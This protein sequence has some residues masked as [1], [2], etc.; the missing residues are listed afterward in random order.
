MLCALLVACAPSGQT[1]QSGA[2]GPSGP[3]AATAMP[4]AQDAPSATGSL[5]DGPTG[6]QTGDT[7]PASPAMARDGLPTGLPFASAGEPRVHMPAP[8]APSA[9][10][11]A[12]VAA[13]RGL[14]DFAL[15]EPQGQDGPSGQG[16][17]YATEAQGAFGDAS[18]RPVLRILYNASTRGTL[19][20][21]PS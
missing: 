8:A 14:A 20:P 12:P 15:V 13:P 6:G 3:A 4:P 21:C 1:G 5:T 17:P 19:H 10:E 18:G 7:A 11:T 9:T 2:A 16:G